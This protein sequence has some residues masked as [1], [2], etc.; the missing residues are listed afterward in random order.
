MNEKWSLDGRCARVVW[1][2]T[3]NGWTYTWT[4]VQGNHNVQASA[5]ECCNSTYATFEVWTD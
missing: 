4:V 5:Y 3:Q 2:S 1:D